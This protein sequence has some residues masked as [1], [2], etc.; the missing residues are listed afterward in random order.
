MAK[1]VFHSTFVSRLDRKLELQDVARNNAPASMD[2]TIHCQAIVSDAPK[3][4]L[5]YDAAI[6]KTRATLDALES[7]RRTI[8]EYHGLCR[9]VLAPIRR[10]PPE[11]LTSVFECFITPVPWIP[12]TPD[13]A[14]TTWKDL[15]KQETEEVGNQALITLSRV[16]Q[17]WNNIIMGT[18]TLWS[19]VNL[20]LSVWADPEEAYTRLESPLNKVLLRGQ[21]TPLTI[22]VHDTYGRTPRNGWKRTMA[23]LL[24]HSSRW[25]NAFF[26]QSPMAF[27]SYDAPNPDFP[28]LENLHLDAQFKDIPPQVTSFFREVPRLRTLELR[29]PVGHLHSLGLP[30]EQLGSLVLWGVPPAALNDVLP[31]VS[32][33]PKTSEAHIMI[34]MIPNTSV[35]A[36][37]YNTGEITSQ[38]ESC[39]VTGYAHTKEVDGVMTRF[40]L[41]QIFQRLNLPRVT[42]LGFDYHAKYVPMPWPHDEFV[43]FAARSS[44]KTHLT[45]INLG[46][47]VVN[48]PQM[49]EILGNLPLLTFL[50]ISD[51]KVV[52]K[53]DV[54]A[55]TNTVLH[56]L[57]R[58]DSTDEGCLCPNL[59]SFTFFSHLEF[60]EGVCRDFI[61][62]RVSRGG[63]GGIK[64]FELEVCWYEMGRRK[65][66]P[67]EFVEAKQLDAQG[68]MKFA[69]KG[70]RLE[71]EK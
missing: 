8:Q 14:L 58:K 69:I 52:D 53:S 30:F 11:V 12:W 50:L 26:S 48:E 19:A 45:R 54:V 9:S 22:G 47:V 13:E 7:E 64:K 44:L 21:Q 10:L 41:G 33:L 31:V 4:L 23:L 46:W 43:A 59:N 40:V 71:N 5:E 17:R 34:H 65:P 28:D 63:K 6:S 37:G 1:P 39:T 20:D 29:S 55:V 67:D 56:R 38:L 3:E 70:Y 36:A 68:K 16:C 49:L 35:S 66:G 25:K 32:R 2:Q 27:A 42:F 61:T 18:P 51:H 15:L 57:T 62:S 60:D 24:R